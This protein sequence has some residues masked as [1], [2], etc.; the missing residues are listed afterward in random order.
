[1][2]RK[3]CETN[4]KNFNETEFDNLVKDIVNDEVKDKGGDIIKKCC[5]CNLSTDFK[6]DLAKLITKDM[7]IYK[8]LRR[9]IFAIE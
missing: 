3:Y 9:E 8:D 5:N 6:T 1:M 4:G 2:L 7:D